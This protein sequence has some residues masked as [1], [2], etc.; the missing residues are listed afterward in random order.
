M[1]EIK[2]GNWNIKGPGAYSL[3]KQDIEAITE[4]QEIID[5]P[6]AVA[7]KKVSGEISKKLREKKPDGWGIGTKYPYKKKL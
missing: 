6:Q 1:V 2:N 4:M 7:I 5:D 3:T